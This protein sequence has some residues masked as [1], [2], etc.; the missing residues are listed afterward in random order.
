MSGLRYD[1]NIAF[2][3]EMWVSWGL[4]VLSYLCVLLG[5]DGVYVL[6]RFLLTLS[7]LC[8]YLHRVNLNCLSL[9]PDGFVQGKDL[10]L[11]PICFAG[12]WAAWIKRVQWG[13]AWQW[14][15]KGTHLSL[16]FPLKT[17]VFGDKLRWENQQLG[18]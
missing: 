15:W 11:D 9:W 2:M 5:E 12:Y 1:W 4:Y 14:G 13:C 10:L 3:L 17:I 7:C 6:V 18:S 16:T 8:T